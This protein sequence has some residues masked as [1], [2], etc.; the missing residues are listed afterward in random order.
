MLAQWIP[1]AQLR[2]Q[3]QQAAWDD[4]ETSSSMNNYTEKSLKLDIPTVNVQEHRDNLLEHIETTFGCDW[5]KR[6][7]LLKELW[8]SSEL[9]NSTRRLS[10]HGLLQEEL[11]IPY[12]TDARVKGALTP[13]H[14]GRLCDVLR[15][16]TQGAPHKIATQYL[17]QRYPE[18]IQEVAPAE[19][20]ES[21]FGDYFDPHRVVGSGPF[22]W[23]PAI[24]TVPLFVAGSSSSPTIESTSDNQ[25]EQQDTPFTGL[26]CEPIGNVAV[27]LSGQKQWT[28][29]SPEYTKRLRPSLAPDGRAFFASNIDLHELT[30]SAQV[31]IYS[32]MTK[33]GDAIWVPTWTWHRVDYVPSP[34]IAIGGSLFHFRSL[35]FARNHPLFAILIIPALLLEVIGYKTQ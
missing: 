1:N 32:T 27:Q 29:V 34:E 30:S 31:P 25:Q 5:R 20:V 24:T 35:D 12:F 11:E 3:W 6:P 19:I 18:L 15:N 23:F 8:S 17:I 26:H 13:D 33:A 7:L 21:L 22:H 14:K 16:I 4:W 28:L 10:L 2:A 9:Q